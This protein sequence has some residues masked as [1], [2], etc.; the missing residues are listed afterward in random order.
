ML[1]QNVHIKSPWLAALL[2][3][4]PVPLGFGYLYLRLPSRCESTVYRSMAAGVAGL[5]LF[6]FIYSLSIYM[7]PD[8]SK[9]AWSIPV[10]VLAGTFPIFL[11]G[12]FTAR[13][14]WRIAKAQNQ[15]RQ[16]DL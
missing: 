5:I 13:D 8:T 7:N 4:A 16:L 12:L 14:A 9:Q 6:G 10:G 3:L 15:Q 2:N 11:L 1:L